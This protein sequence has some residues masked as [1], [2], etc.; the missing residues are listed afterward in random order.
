MALPRKWLS[1]FLVRVGVVTALLALCPTPARAHIALERSSPAKDAH[2]ATAP[3][4]VRL[5]FNGSVEPRYTSVRILDPRGVDVQMSILSVVPGTSNREFVAMPTTSAFQIAGV[6]TVEWKSA[7][8]DGH[9][10]TGSYSFTLSIAPEAVPDSVFLPSDH[11]EARG[12]LDEQE[13]ISPL[14]AI[15]VRWVNF[16][17]LIGLIGA[18]VFRVAILGRVARLSPASDLVSNAARRTWKYACAIALLAAIALVARLWIQSA[19]LHGVASA[20]NPQLLGFMISETRW[21]N[22]WL[23]QLVGTMVVGVSLIIIARRTAAR[24]AWQLLAIATGLLAIVPALSGHASA[25]EPFGGLALLTDIIHVFAAGA[26]I[27]SLA[28]LVWCGLPALRGAH[29]ADRVP[30]L[31]LM[32]RSFS[33]V[34]LVAVALLLCS[35][36]ISAVLHLN[37]LSDLLGSAYG[38]ALS[39][40]L[41]VLA[42][43]LGTGFYNWRFVQPALSTD[44]ANVKLRL[45]ATVEIGVAIIVLLITAVLVALPTP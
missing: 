15:A 12:S 16:A 19:S 4:E 35:G 28:A 42:V 13:T 29:D 24:R 44:T 26:W 10:I 40:K 45:S 36:V 1:W 41:A 25:T 27:G 21:G 2:L 33:N 11:H 30:V 39:L 23:I 31:V 43:V 7:G 14:L 37:A 20:W 6:Y 32:V 8:A 3:R 5:R 9:I 38:R 18:V 22:A 34:A 17:A